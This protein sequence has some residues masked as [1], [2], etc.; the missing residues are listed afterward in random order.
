MQGKVLIKMVNLRFSKAKI[1]FAAVVLL[2]MVI[3]VTVGL[4]APGDVPPP[5][6][7]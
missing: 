4:G 1:I 6:G 5:P 7:I 3:Q 2:V